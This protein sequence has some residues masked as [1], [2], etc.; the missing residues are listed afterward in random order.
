VNIFFKD[1]NDSYDLRDEANRGFTDIRV[2]HYYN[3]QEFLKHVSYIS[4]G[5]LGLFTVLIS[6]DSYNLNGEY[7]FIGLS[8]IILNVF[9]IISILR[10]RLNADSRGLQKQ[11][12]EYNILINFKIKLID[13][14]LNLP[15]LSEKEV[16]GFQNELVNN[17]NAKKLN[18]EKD[19]LDK[20]MLSRDKQLLDHSF[21]LAVFLFMTG[22]LFITISVINKNFNIYHLFVAIFI[23]FLISFNDTAS[24]LVKNINQAINF[25][26]NRLK[27]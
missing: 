7:L 19:E 1:L 17:E 6:K 4:S 14:Y 11:Q 18:R 8:L 13:K 5:I 3:S 23:I 9:Y 21:E 26:K 16:L 12:D 25:L 10:E 27:K 15:Q 2:K 24:I 20:K 22:V